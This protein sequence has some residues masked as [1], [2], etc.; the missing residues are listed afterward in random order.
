MSNLHTSRRS[1]Q[2]CQIG[3]I[4]LKVWYR[5]AKG[6][7]AVKPLNYKNFHKRPTHYFNPD[8]KDRMVR[9]ALA[10]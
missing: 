10:V 4:R 1:Y 9:V 2:I 3:I 5:F 6:V 7:R 8:T